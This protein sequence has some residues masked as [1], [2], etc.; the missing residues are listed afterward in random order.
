M[1]IQPIRTEIGASG[2]EVVSQLGYPIAVHANGSRW[3]APLGRTD[4][5]PEAYVWVYAS[6]NRWIVHEG[7][8]VYVSFKE[9]KVSGVYAKYDDLPMYWRPAPE[10]DRPEKMLRLKQAL[11]R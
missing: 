4:P 11:G 6:P 5:W 9:G 3:M 1:T 7:L 10:G 2:G 8:A